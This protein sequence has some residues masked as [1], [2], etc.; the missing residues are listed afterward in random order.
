[1]DDWLKQFQTTLR[2][3]ARESSNQ[4]AEVSEQAT[5][6]VERWVDESIEVIDR[7][8][9]AIAPTVEDFGEQVESTLDAGLLFFTENISP[10]IEEATAPISN[11]V[12]PWLQNHPTCIGC[13]NYH[14]SSYGDE[15]L[16]C[17]MHPYG[18]EDS[19]CM[20]WE[21]VWPIPQDDT[22]NG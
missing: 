8:E 18:P 22:N 2:E 17:G 21:S 20:D 12:N 1:M 6:V 9:K 11:T 10:I 16:V 15:M 13:K 4:W 3:A 19:S 14:G 7:A 5:Q